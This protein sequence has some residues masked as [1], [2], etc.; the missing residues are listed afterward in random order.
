VAPPFSDASDLFERAWYG[1]AETGPDDSAA[2]R[3]LADEVAS[4]AGP[5]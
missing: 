1:G 4:G 3:R 2:F 5:S